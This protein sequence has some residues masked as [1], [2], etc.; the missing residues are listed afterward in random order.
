MNQPYK[1]DKWECAIIRAFKRGTPENPLTINMLLEIWGERCCMDVKYI[2]LNY[3]TEHMFEVARKLG[4]LDDILYSFVN[5]LNPKE[6]WK[7]VC[8]A[9]PYK[10]DENDFDMILLSRLDS[11]FSLATIKE[12]NGY[13]EYL[14]SIGKE[15]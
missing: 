2:D 13:E 7:Y 5:S 15:I 1:L 14:T 4:L 10:K 9:N 8:R 3:I 6:N 12:L 11:L